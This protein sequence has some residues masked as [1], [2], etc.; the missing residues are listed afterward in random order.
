MVG[1]ADTLAPEPR[2]LLQAYV[3]PV[4]A[5]DADNDVALPLQTGLTEAATDI[6][7]EVLNVTFTWVRGLSQVPLNSLT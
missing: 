4:F 7:G 1:L 3:Y 2:L 6:V 5:L